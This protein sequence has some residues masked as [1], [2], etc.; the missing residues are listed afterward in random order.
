MPKPTRGPLRTM[1]KR[2]EIPA[3]PGLEPQHPRASLVD[4]VPAQT[5][6][7]TA[8]RREAEA[9]VHFHWSSRVE[10]R[11]TNLSPD[12]LRRFEQDGTYDAQVLVAGEF[13]DSGWGEC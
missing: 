7:K 8:Y 11:V 10:L 2:T 1:M 12:S 3:T 6:F 9:R 13:S 4:R 5:R